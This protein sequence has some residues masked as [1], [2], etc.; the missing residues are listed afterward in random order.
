MCAPSERIARLEGLHQPY[1]SPGYQRNRAWSPLRLDMPLDPAVIQR[2][3]MRVCLLESVLI[4][5]VLIDREVTGSLPI[6][7]S[8]EHARTNGGRARSPA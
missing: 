6:V 8:D 1:P 5:S 3:A 4:E 2:E 7:S